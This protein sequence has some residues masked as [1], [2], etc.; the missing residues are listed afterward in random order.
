MS[1]MNLLDR[2]ARRPVL[3]LLLLCSLVW[4]PGF[5]SLPPLD[6]DE[7]RFAQASKQMIESR[8]YIDIRFSTVPRYNKP[9]GVYWLQAA[10]TEILGSAPYNQIWTY[11]VPSLFGAFA[12]VLL[13]YWLARAIASPPAALLAAGFMSVCLL[14]VIEAKIATTDALLLATI[15]A[16]QGLILRAY[17]HARGRL[18]RAPSIWTALG[19]WAAIG[20]G[21]L[22][23]GPVIVSVIALTVIT[24]SVWD[25]DWKWLRG[26]RAAPGVV[27]LGAV[28][29][30]WAIAI[31]ITSHGTF[32]ERSL[33]HDF[34]AKLVEGQESHGAPPGFYLALASLTLWPITLYALPALVS[35]ISG[36]A[37]P[38]MRYMLAWI[39]PNWI[40]FELVPTKLPHYILPVYPALALLSALC[41]ARQGHEGQ[42]SGQ[43]ASRIIAVIQFALGGLALS[44][45]AVIFRWR[46]GGGIPPWLGVA[47]AVGF[48]ASVAVPA[49]ALLHKRSAA[50]IGALALASILEISLSIS[51]PGLRQIWLSS[52]ISQRIA[53]DRKPDDPPVTLAGYAEPS[54]IFLLGTRTHAENGKAA[55][56][57]AALQGGLAVVNDRAR[58]TFLKTVHEQGAVATAMDRI[59]GLN[60]SRGRNERVTIFRVQPAPGFTA[61]PPE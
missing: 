37:E 44:A 53:A 10:S 43:R 31:A 36:R 41:A 4:L 54:L 48:A 46:F 17:L 47:A 32:Y 49:A 39:M 22:L 42:L 16:A 5:F 2:L 28:V 58:E 14:L 9:V 55:A 30:P 6:R 13:L 50:V 52:R 35:A 38:V 61:P 40:L 26:V 56:E 24:I 12:A 15:V 57:T 27:A 23:K 19:C 11:R 21:I 18:E 45:G 33:G 59:S 51:A 7:S 3:V 1:G 60:Y 8:N 20:A 34:A 25:Q 29:L